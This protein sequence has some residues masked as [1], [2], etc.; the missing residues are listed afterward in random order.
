MPGTAGHPSIRRLNATPAVAAPRARLLFDQSGFTLVEL[1]TAATV[2][3]VG[4]LGVV[5]MIAGANVRTLAT[6]GREGA[7][8]VQRELVERARAIPYAQMTEA[9]AISQLQAVPGLEDS[10]PSP[11][12]QISR[13]GF[14]YT[15]AIDVCSVDDGKDQYGAHGAGVFCAGSPTGTQDV[16]PDD[17]KVLSTDITW[18]QPDGHGRSRQQTL[19]NSPGNNVGPS[20]CAIT[21]GGSANTTITSVLA[22]L[23]VGLCVSFAPSTLSVSVDGKVVGNAAGSGTLWT[24]PWA[25][26]TLVDGSY[27]LSARAFDDQGRPGAARSVTV[28]LNRFL[29][30][31]PTGLAAGRNG[32]V[33]EAEW[34]ANR[35]RD[36]VGY[37]LY[38]GA[39]P[40]ASCTNVDATSCQDS[41]PPNLP[42]LTYTLRAVDR[43]SAGNLREGVASAPV[44]VTQ[45]NNRPNP[46]TG[47]ALTTNAEGDAVL[48]WSAPVPDDPDLADQIAFYRIYR[49]GTAVANRFDRTGLGS[50]HTWTDA[51]S[52]GESH[53]YWV[54]AVD[55]QLAESVV[56][57]PVGT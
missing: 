9:S 6:R 11:G 22:S 50:E 27:L 55:S 44:V 48:S 1:L 16:N 43:D 4:V 49:D 15:V 18:S 34:L 17:Y 24:Y 36:I 19:V 35:E 13:R 33:V 38:R 10:S 41:S 20:I 14:V 8:N 5:A 25:I 32:A 21:L 51:R 30:L 39:T 37:R 2:L 28:T 47:L 42:L 40:V 57:G 29:P 31:A 26:D 7:T 53:Q 3:V 23:D 46:P 12:Y 52:T 56:L 54:T 45:L